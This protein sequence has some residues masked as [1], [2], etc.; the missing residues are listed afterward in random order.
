M[1]PESADLATA[2]PARP[3]AEA[4]NERWKTC[5]RFASSSDYD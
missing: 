2:V 5:T 4:S 1:F 3:L